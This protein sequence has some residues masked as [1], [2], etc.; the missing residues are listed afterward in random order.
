MRISLFGSIIILIFLSTFK[1]NTSIFSNSNFLI[2]KIIIENNEITKSQDIKKK[3]NFLYKSN[4][5]FL[6]TRNIRNVL[7]NEPFIQSFRIKKIYP[8][9]IKISISEKKLVAILLNNKKKFYITNKGK[10]I[11]YK[12]IE[13]YKNLPTIIGASNEFIDLY[14]VLNNLDF[15]IK[16]IKSFY[17]YE[18]GR[19]DLALH[20]GRI[21]KLPSKNYKISLRKF[22]KIKNKSNFKKFK[23]FDY[24]IKNQ[25]ILN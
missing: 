17:F 1:P 21:V 24:R 15:P 16:S 7:L 5:V 11:R 6:N 19:W 10:K 8:D 3:L 12:Y 23:T 14:R 22:I 9:I 18:I 2:K 13:N 25:L 4:L 20:D